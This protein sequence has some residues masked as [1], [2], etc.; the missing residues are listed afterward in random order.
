MAWT[1]NPIMEWHDG[2]NWIQIS[3]HGRSALS[4]SIER[5]ENKNR[6][7]DGTLRRYVVAKKKNFSCSWDNFPS[8]KTS[9]LANGDWAGNEMEAFHNSTDGAFQM[10]LRAGSAQDTEILGSNIVEFTVM[11]SDFS[12]EVV[13]RGQGFD[14]WS[15]SVTLEEV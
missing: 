2:T 8:V 5:I 14:L 7:A 12:K 3:D 13:K 10:R 15:M 1:T 9:F 6:M 11:I 4:I